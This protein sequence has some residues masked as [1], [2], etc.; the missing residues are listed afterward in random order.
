MVIKMKDYEFYDKFF[1]VVAFQQAYCNVIYPIP[2]LEKPVAIFGSPNIL[3]P[4][5][6]KQSSRPSTKGKEGTSIGLMSSRKCSRCD[7][8]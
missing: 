1:Y 5:S 8:I 3:P 2:D 4:G 6:K 7:D